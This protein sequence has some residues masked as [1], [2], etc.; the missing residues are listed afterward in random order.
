MAAFN[1][2]YIILKYRE[3]THSRI[4]NLL[5]T[6]SVCENTGKRKKEKNAEGNSSNK[7]VGF[8]QY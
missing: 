3:F 1:F 7:S 2:R 5:S 8:V 4:S 6:D